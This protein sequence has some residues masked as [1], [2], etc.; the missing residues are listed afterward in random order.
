MSKVLKSTSAKPPKML[1]SK[2]SLAGPA[3]RR[4]RHKQ[5]AVFG[6]AT[7]KEVVRD[8]PGPGNYEPKYGGEKPRITD[9]LIMGDQQTHSYIPKNS[10]DIPGPG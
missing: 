3:P 1:A 4:F 5:G 8:S 2:P 9:V 6:S 10:R 7:K